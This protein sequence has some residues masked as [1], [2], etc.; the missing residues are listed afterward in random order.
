[1]DVKVE[2]IEEFGREM[3]WKRIGC[4]VL[5][6][7]FVLRRIDES[8]LLTWDFRHTYRIQ[9]QKGMGIFFESHNKCELHSHL[10]Q[11]KKIKRKALMNNNMVSKA[12]L[13][14]DCVV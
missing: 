12:R 7:S 3:G 6:E 10:P 5:V 8:L 2:K 13:Q 9:K 11:K 14:L 1:M 4:Y